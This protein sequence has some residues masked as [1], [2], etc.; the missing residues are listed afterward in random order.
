M[1]RSDGINP[2]TNPSLN[3]RA[4]FSLKNRVNLLPEC[5]FHSFRFKR[6]DLPENIGV[7]LV[8]TAKTDDF[9]TDYLQQ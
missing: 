8:V 9:A 6:E 3:P 2:L 1:G 5:D 4:P 7:H